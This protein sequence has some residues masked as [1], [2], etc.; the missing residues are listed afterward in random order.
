MSTPTLNEASD[1]AALILAAL[2]DND[3]AVNTVILDASRH[4]TRELAALLR[5]TVT[6]AAEAVRKEL[7]A[8]VER[9]DDTSPAVSY[10]AALARHAQRQGEGR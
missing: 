10:L 7:L 6:A 8:A 2:D 5:W 9:G 3:D 4:G 1:A